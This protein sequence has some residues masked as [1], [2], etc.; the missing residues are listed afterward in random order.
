M[1]TTGFLIFSL[2]LSRGGGWRGAEGKREG[3][4]QIPHPA[5]S[6]VQDSVPGPRDHNLS[7]KQGCMLNRLEQPRH[8]PGF[9]LKHLQ[10]EISS[11]SSW[12]PFLTGT[13]LV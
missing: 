3:D 11:A 8:L 13:Y 12:Q 2:F 6:Q 10:W 9:L 1:V 7:Q 4:K 5:W